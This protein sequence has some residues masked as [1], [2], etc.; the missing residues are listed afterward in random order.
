MN[1]RLPRIRT[2]RAPIRERIPAGTDRTADG[3]VQVVYLTL[4]SITFLLAV[5]SQGAMP[6]G[7]SRTRS[8]R[9]RYTL[10]ALK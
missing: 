5:F 10:Y 3:R 8:R 9:K 7:K 2:G 1:I 6:R 4:F